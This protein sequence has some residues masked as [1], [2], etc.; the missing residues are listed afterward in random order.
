MEF[1][2]STHP[3]S[4]KIY[5][6]NPCTQ[7]WENMTPE[8]QGRYCQSCCKTVTD[9]SGMT[10]QEII[11]IIK[12]SSG[13]ICGRLHVSQLNRK[14]VEP[15]A[16]RKSFL[17]AAVFA[18]LI[19]FVSQ[20]EAGTP[21]APMA[22]YSDTTSKDDPIQ[23]TLPYTITG[24]ITDNSGSPL[25]GAFVNIHDS[26]FYAFADSSGNFNLALPSAF[27]DKEIKLQFSSI[28]YNTIETNLQITGENIVLP[29]TMLAASIDNIHIT[30]G[31][32]SYKYNEKNPKR[33]GLKKLFH[34]RR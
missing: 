19:T 26:K 8:A 14:L 34:F 24:R 28:G 13:E 7:S 18:S 21:P 17:P 3:V 23:D 9:F 10:D 4:M 29:V 11:S 31:A 12:A 6:S 5:V 27:K 33:R 30:M 1:P 25:Y 16:P 15:A 22:L 20:A 2:L 32:V